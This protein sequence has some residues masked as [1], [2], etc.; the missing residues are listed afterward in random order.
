MERAGPPVGHDLPRRVAQLDV[1]SGD[2]PARRAGTDL[3]GPVRQEDVQLLGRPDPVDDLDAEPREEPVL[4][5]CRQGLPRRGREPHGGERVVGKVTRQQRCVEGG[6]AEEERGPTGPRPLPDARRCRPTGLEQGRG[7]D[8][9]R[10][11]Q[12]VADA[13]GEEQLRHREAHVVRS[14][15]ED[16]VTVGLAD[17]PDV[18]VAVHGA[19]GRARRARGVEPQGPR[20]VGGGSDG[21]QGL[22]G[23]LTRRHEVGERGDT[24]SERHARAEVPVGDDVPQLGRERDRLL[25]LGLVCGAGDEDLRAGVGDD[26]PELGSTEHGRHGDRDD[27]RPEGSEDGPDHG[28]V[29]VHDHDDPVVATQPEGAQTGGHVGGQLGEPGIREVAA[30]PD[31]D[32]VCATSL[33]LTLDEPGLGVEGGGHGHTRFRS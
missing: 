19:L 29:V 22:V 8:G 26:L 1:I 32:V 9:E 13:V 10:E 14:D 12:G 30:P 33:D 6:H 28:H 27:A 5:G 18:G 21:P 11:E 31:G 23:A 17:V 16:L 3:A 2:R 20:V 7:P 15:A 24:H 25:D 4:E